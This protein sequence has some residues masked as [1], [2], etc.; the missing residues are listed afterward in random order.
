MSGFGE[1]FNAF[2]IIVWHS[3]NLT[4]GRIR[5]IPYLDVFKIKELKV[6][7]IGKSSHL[8][9]IIIIILYFYRVIQSAIY[10]AA[11]KRSPV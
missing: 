8:I 7:L 11:I 10:I 5:F 3:T 4:D 1:D 2:R 6:A 9:I